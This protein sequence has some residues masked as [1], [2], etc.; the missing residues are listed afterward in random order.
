M[1]GSFFV[2]KNQVWVAADSFTKSLILNSKDGGRTW[3]ETKLKNISEG[4]PLFFNKERGVIFL[5]KEIILVT[6]DCGNSWR[7]MRKPIRKYP[8][9]FS[10]L[11]E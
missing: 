2:D 5:N 11:F 9:H 10:K 1:A 6:R 7:R 4:L 3:N 8:W